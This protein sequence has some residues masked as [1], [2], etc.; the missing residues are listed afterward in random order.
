M[1]ALVTVTIVVIAALVGVIASRS[2]DA[3]PTTTTSMITT[4]TM[5]TITVPV[6]L[7]STLTEAE[8]ALSSLR[9]GFV[10]TYVCRGGTAVANVV[11]SQSPA[12]GGRTAEG[13]EVEL[14][15]RSPSCSSK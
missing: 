8:N 13:S 1:G 3:P 9:L 2:N 10:V 4:T 12:G 14:I 6:L 7:G 5:E 11:E 15:V